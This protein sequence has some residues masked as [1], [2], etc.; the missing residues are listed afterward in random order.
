MR[1]PWVKFL[2]NKPHQDA[3]ES[4]SQQIASDAM[5]GKASDFRSQSN[6]QESGI[7]N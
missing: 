3:D 1:N 6:Q 5:S 4:D 2:G 7:Q